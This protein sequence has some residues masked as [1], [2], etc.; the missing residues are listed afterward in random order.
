VPN[1]LGYQR[2]ANIDRSLTVSKQRDCRRQVRLHTHVRWRFQ[3]A[4][5]TRKTTLAQTPN[6][7]P[8]SNLF[9]A[10]KKKEK[11]TK[12]YYHPDSLAFYE[13]LA[14]Y[15]PTLKIKLD[16]YPVKNFLLFSQY[17]K[18]HFLIFL[19]TLCSVILYLQPL[20]ECHFKFCIRK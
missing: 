13:Y 19:F 20:Q 2:R 3:R 15:A 11:Q 9:E 18:K 10:N 6:T 5:A 16:K 17:Q 14:L 7:F 8:K 12:L 4:F 1:G